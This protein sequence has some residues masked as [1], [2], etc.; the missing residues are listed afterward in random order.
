MH[1]ILRKLIGG[2]RRSIG[3]S[4]EVVSDVLKNPGLLKV[5]ITGL[6]V[7]YP[8][9]RMRTADAMEKISSVNPEFLSPYKG[10]LIEQATTSDQK[11]VRWHLAQILPRIKLSQK[12][13]NQVVDVLLSYFSDSSSIVKTFS[14]QALADIARQRPNL[15]PS[16]LTHLREYTLTGTPAMK[17]RGRK[18]LTEIERLTNHS[19]QKRS[20]HRTRSHHRSNG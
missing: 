20:K 16:I 12:E 6:R 17:A 3:R 18:L 11:E 19:T 4:E 5:L 15:R 13:T 7:S 14:M 1:P 9:V 10:L 2:D 8:V